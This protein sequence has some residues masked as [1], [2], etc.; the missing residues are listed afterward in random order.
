MQRIQCRSEN[1][2]GVYCLQYDDE[3]I[4]SGLRDNSIKVNNCILHVLFLELW[5]HVRHET[6]QA[7]HVYSGLV[8]LFHSVSAALGGSEELGAVLSCVNTRPLGWLLILTYPSLSTLAFYAVHLAVHKNYLRA[9][10][11]ILSFT[12]Q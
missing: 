4:I 11:I 9:I 5:L 1:S 12:F 8:Y 7:C 10:W 2:K 3:K 6:R